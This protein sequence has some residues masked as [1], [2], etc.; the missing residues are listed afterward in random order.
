MSRYTIY[1][2]NNLEEKLKKYMEY[3][4]INKRSVAIKDCIEK[5]V[6]C[7]SDKN[8][9]EDIDRKLNIILHRLSLNKVLAEQTFANFSFDKNVDLA[10][11]KLLKKI[12]NDYTQKHFGKLMD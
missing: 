6:N 12:Y 10:E 4:N 3:E 11:D 7:E 5:M 9:I 1:L 8:Y 2:D